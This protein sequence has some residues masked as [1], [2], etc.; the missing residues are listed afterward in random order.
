MCEAEST[1]REIEDFVQVLGRVRVPLE[2]LYRDEMT[3]IEQESDPWT[4]NHDL[5]PS[6]GNA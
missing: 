4:E 6:G 5:P 1:T 3:R 2:A